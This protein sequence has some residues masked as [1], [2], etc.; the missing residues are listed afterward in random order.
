MQAAARSLPKSFVSSRH[1]AFLGGFRAKLKNKTKLN[2]MRE[3]YCR[4]Q[5]KNVEKANILY[6]ISANG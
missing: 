2:E 4:F 3:K 6:D 5:K 1:S